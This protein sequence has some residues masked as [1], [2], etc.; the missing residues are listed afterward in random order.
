MDNIVKEIGQFFRFILNP[1]LIRNPASKTSL[2]RSLCFA[3][4]TISVGFV[5]DLISKIPAIVKY[6]CYNDDLLNNK[7]FMHGIFFSFFIGGIIAPILEEFIFRFYLNSLLGNIIYLFINLFIIL[8]IFY[9]FEKLQMVI[10][11][12]AV[13]ISILLV[14][15]LFEQSILFREKLSFFVTKYFQIFFYFSVLTFAL[16]HVSNLEI[17]NQH[18]FFIILLLLPQFFGGL[19]FSYARLKWGLKTSILI[20]SL[21]NLIGIM[22]MYLI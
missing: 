5:L 2:V 18:S 10:Y 15:I 11:I 14:S 3:G 21:N 17:C 16:V 4:L 20:H 9:G 8:Q 12:L 13:I 7:M 6:F 19:I 22:I 1:F